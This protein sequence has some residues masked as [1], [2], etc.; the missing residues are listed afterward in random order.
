M[1][2]NR[3]A[4]VAL[5]VAGTSFFCAC[6]VT[7]NPS[8]KP[9]PLASPW[10]AR[11]PKL[12]LA[13]VT[14]HSD[15]V[16]GATISGPYFVKPSGPLDQ[17]LREALV[18]EFARLGIPLVKTAKDSDASVSAVLTAAT[19][20]SVAGVG[21]NGR[22]AP[23]T[24]KIGFS[25]KGRNNAPLYNEELV[26]RSGPIAPMW[27]GKL[28][29]EALTA[30][31]ADAMKQVEDLFLTQDLAGR[32]FAAENQ[33][34][35]AAAPA[36]TAAVRSDIDELPNVKPVR[37]K[38]H[39]VVIG[40]ELY[41]QQLPQA[42]FAASDARLTAKYLIDV[43]GYPAENVVT[44]TND[45]ATRGDIEKYVE[46]WLP[47]RVEAGDS[48]FVYYSGHGSPNP[49]TGDAYLVPYDGDPAYLDQTAYPLSRLYNALAKLPTKDV[50]V[51]LDSCFSGAGGRSVIA[52]GARPLVNAQS[53]L[54]IPGS[55]T[56]L[57]AAGANQI[58]QSYQEK[59]H[60]L[61]TYF[62]LKSIGL[63]AAKGAVRMK[64]AFDYAAPQVGKVAR[65][66]Y[67]SEQTPQWREGSH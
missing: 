4:A 57:S 21:G 11:K 49:T 29:N 59:G 44:L 39:A 5:V 51:A 15:G 14:D 25:V 60:G 52:K 41:R 61:F 45:G 54:E 8:Y 56:V 36:P 26:G 34:A 12:F 65:Q 53:K 33:A 66:E 1:S 19:L 67:N 23:S 2:P 31:L 7:L 62:F 22:T 18:N 9:L 50:T 6:T 17:Y 35:A 64:D 38:A 47:N 32:I 20:P 27:A 42:D 24:M 37:R 40:I 13:A 63:Q 28:A 3:L 43:L 10:E 58:S 55:L 48:V 46:R 30:A 16:G